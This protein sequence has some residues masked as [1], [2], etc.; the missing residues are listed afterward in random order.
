MY[1]DIIA[2][3]RGEGISAGR[4]FGIDVAKLAGLPAEVIAR[5]REVLREHEQAEQRVTDE[6]SAAGP[7]PVE[8]V[9]L[10]MFT[11]LSQQVVDRLRDTDLNQLT[12]L[13]A[14]NL[15]HELKKQME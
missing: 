2:R 8:T 7:P 15:L 5:A 4:S 10:T 3:A 11:P 13:E 1:S 6:L 9:Q 12:P 14:L